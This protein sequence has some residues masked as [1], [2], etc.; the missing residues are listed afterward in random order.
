MERTEQLLKDTLSLNGPNII[1]ADWVITEVET[2]QLENDESLPPIN[3]PGNYE[4]L[5]LM[6]VKLLCNNFFSC[7]DVNFIS[8]M[9]IRGSVGSNL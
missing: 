1:K 9:D 6:Y 3:E 8:S 2:P 7:T 4:C 5:V